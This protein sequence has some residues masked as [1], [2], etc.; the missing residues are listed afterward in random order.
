MFYLR[1]GGGTKPKPIN[2][3]YYSRPSKKNFEYATL[4][5]IPASRWDQANQCPIKDRRGRMTRENRRIYESILPYRVFL[6]STINHF[7]KENK[8]LTVEALR[9]E[10]DKEF[11]RKRKRETL[12]EYVDDVLPLFIKIKTDTKALEESSIQKYKTL[13]LHLDNFGQKHKIRLKLVDLDTDFYKNFILYCRKDLS[14]QDNSL[15]RY[16]ISL[17]SFLR[18]AEENGYRTNP[19]FKD[20]QNIDLTSV[21]FALN[22]AEV[23]ILYKFNFKNDA[24]RRSVDV[25]TLGCYVGQMY[26]D[27]K[28]LKKENIKDGVAIITQQ[29]T[30]NLSV[31]TRVQIPLNK[32]VT[33]ILKKYKYQLPLVSIQKFNSDLKVA[34]K[35]AGFTEV[36]E[37]VYQ[38]G[39]IG[40]TEKVEKWQRISSNIMRRTFVKMSLEKGMSLNEIAMVTGHRHLTSIRKYDKT[41]LESLREKVY[42]VYGSPEPRMVA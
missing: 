42:S 13:G 38:I 8:D 37:K 25:F 31:Q 6:Q 36:S 27:L 21:T 16:I 20:F 34:A 23:L 41:S 5:K 15:G 19:T 12:S 22:E 29:K 7:N 39:A 40:F 11:N 14:L 2:L 35:Q 1:A 33:E 30:K 26:T 9:Y 24:L 32:L 3:K 4:E 17:K 10:F 28:E 18:W